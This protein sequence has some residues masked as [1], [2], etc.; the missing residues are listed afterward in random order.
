[1]Q[2]ITVTPYGEAE[3]YTLQGNGGLS[4]SVITYGATLVDITYKGKP[5]ILSHANLEEYKTAEGYW[6]ATVGRYAN[7]IEKGKFTLEGVEYDV[8]CNEAGRYHLHG[9][10]VGTDKKMWAAKIVDE[11]EPAVEFTNILE[12]GEEGYPGRLEVKV[13]M[14]VCDDN[15]LS[16]SY[17]AVSDKTTVFNPTNHAYFSLGEESTKDIVLN[18]FADAITPIDEMLI[19]TGELMNVGGTPF[20]FRTPKKIGQDIADL[21][22]PQMAICGTYDHNFVIFNTRRAMR[23]AARAVAPSGITLECHTDMPGLQIYAGNPAGFCLE[24]QFYPDSPNKPQ[25]PSCTLKAGEKFQSTTH[26]KFL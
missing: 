9:G 14:R 20:D 23:F 11:N 15:T 8:G 5:M 7:R 24:T 26:Y 3:K 17:E 13:T 22:H 21:S 1:M 10:V 16:I 2:K 19:P 25:F 6:G 18:I 4:V 12:D